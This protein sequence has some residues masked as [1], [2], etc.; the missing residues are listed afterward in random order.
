MLTHSPGGLQ[1]HDWA[2][3][4]TGTRN[5]NWASH[6]VAGPKHSRCLLLLFL[7][8]Q[9]GAELEAEQVGLEP[10]PLRDAMDTSAV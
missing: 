5:S 9:Q 7:M 10:V 8:T 3:L 6:T 1:S 4:R 2:I